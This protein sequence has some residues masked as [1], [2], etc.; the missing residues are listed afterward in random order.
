L[1]DSNT[2]KTKEPFI[3]VACLQIVVKKN[4]V[5]QKKERFFVTRKVKIFFEI[6]NFFFGAASTPTFSASKL[7]KRSSRG[8]PFSDPANNE[9]QKKNVRSTKKIS[10]KIFFVSEPND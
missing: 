8:E 9:A 4:C 7:W 10:S 1:H 5:C 3:V 6:A 2:L